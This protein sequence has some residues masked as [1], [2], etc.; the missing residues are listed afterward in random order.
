[1]SEKSYDEENIWAFDKTAAWSDGSG[2][3]TNEKVGEKEVEMWK[4]RRTSKISRLK[5]GPKSFISNKEKA[6]AYFQ[7]NTVGINARVGMGEL[8]KKP[9][10]CM[11]GWWGNVERRD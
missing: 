7:G 9:R 6:V 11:L 8:E 3:T 5:S 4:N 10:E 1:M 2:N